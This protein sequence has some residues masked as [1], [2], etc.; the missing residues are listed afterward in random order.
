MNHFS[1]IS[2]VYSSILQFAKVI[3]LFVNA[4]GSSAVSS[5][6][7][8]DCKT[9][10]YS[11]AMGDIHFKLNAEAREALFSIVQSSALTELD[12]S[13]CTICKKQDWLDMIGQCRYGFV[14]MSSVFCQCIMLYSQNSSDVGIKFIHYDL[15]KYYSA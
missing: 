9:L 3:I 6:N 14:V 13:H 12:L 15:C 10:R 2:I 1:S 8:S 7:L 11:A 4:Y 5:L